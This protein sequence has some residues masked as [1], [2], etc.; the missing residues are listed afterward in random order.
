M[1]DSFS[2]VSPFMSSPGGAGL[3]VQ[4]DRGDRSSD[5]AQGLRYSWMGGQPGSHHISRVHEV[6]QRCST[7][8]NSAL[9]VKPETN[10]ELKHKHKWEPVL[11]LTKVTHVQ[12][13]NAVKK[14]GLLCFF[15]K[16]FELHNQITPEELV[17]R[18]KKL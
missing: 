1:F 18:L 16:I 9:A 5:D 14:L 2:P 13:E 15:Q 6:L 17:V 7:H 8:G 4:S 3:H 11:S 12:T 10:I